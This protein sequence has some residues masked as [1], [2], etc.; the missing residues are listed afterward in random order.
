MDIAVFG[1]SFDPPH[2]GH[3]K[4]VYE[5]LHHLNIDKLIIVP[6]FLNPF[7]SHFHFSPKIRYELLNQLFADNKKIEISDFEIN[8]NSSSKTID[9]INHLKNIYKPNKLY[10]II[11]ADNVKMLHLWDSFEELK[12]LVIFVIISREGY[13]VKNDIIRFI[14]VEVNI[15]TSSTD[16]RE[17]LDL[18]YVPNKIK[19]KVK[20]LWNKE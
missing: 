18:R 10:L 15:N 11:G 9:T 3:E 16:L 17:N 2:I 13:E 5:V 4:I 19:Q 1:G 14:N 12:D 6:T 20:Q 7:K 8:K